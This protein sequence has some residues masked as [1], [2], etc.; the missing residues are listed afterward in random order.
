MVGLWWF[1]DHCVLGVQARQNNKK[2]KKSPKKFFLNFLTQRGRDPW[3]IMTKIY[4]KRK[5]LKFWPKICITFLNF[6]SYEFGF[7]T[8]GSPNKMQLSAKKLKM[9]ARKDEKFAYFLLINWKF[10]AIF[11]KINSGNWVPAVPIGTAGE[12]F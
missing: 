2:N 3:D 6:K 10:E 1:L 4:E 11:C 7:F 9:M 8:C 5:K 12:N